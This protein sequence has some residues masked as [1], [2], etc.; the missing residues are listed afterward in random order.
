[1]TTFPAISPSTRTYVPGNVPLDLRQGLSGAATGFKR[2]ARRISQTL[3]LSFLNITESDMILIKDHYIARKG[4]FEVFY[5]PSN[6]WGDY[7][8]SPVGI[9]FIWRYSAPPEIEDTSFDRF[10]V[11]VELIAQPINL[12][13]LIFYDALSASATPTRL[14][15]VDSGTASATPAR[16]HVVNPGLAR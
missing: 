5:I 6:I 14:Y 16:T 13:G 8:A 9:E 2:G 1:M 7:T 3:S 10:N 11:T 12:E 15:N 4:T